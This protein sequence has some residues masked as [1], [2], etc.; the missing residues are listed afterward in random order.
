M[1]HTSSPRRHTRLPAL[2]VVVMLSVLAAPAGLSAQEYG[3]SPVFRGYRPSHQ[4]SRP[5]NP[6]PAQQ[7]RDLQLV[8]EANAG[9]Q[10]AQ[11]ELG[12]RYLFGDGFQPDTAKAA[13]WIGKAAA[14]KLALANYNYGL[15][16]ANGWGV[17]WD[18]FSAFRHIRFAAERGQTEAQHVLGLTYTENL[19]VAR[20]WNTALKW[21]RLA[22]DS[23]FT[24]SRA[25]LPELESV[26]RRHSAAD[27]ITGSTSRAEEDDTQPGA[28]GAWSPILLDFR[29]DTVPALPDAQA[30]A[31]DAITTAALRSADSAG[32]LVL[33]AGDSSDATLLHPLSPAAEAGNPEV[34]TFL[35]YCAQEGIGLT[36]DPVHAA[37][38]YIRAIYLESP[39]AAQFLWTLTRMKGFLG[40]LQARVAEGETRAMFVQSELI[41]LDFDGHI[42][43]KQAL[44][45]LIKAAD[46]GNSTAAVHV[47]I[48]QQTG[49]WVVQDREKALAIW[50]SAAAAGNAEAVVRAAAGTL[51]TAGATDVDAADHLTILRRADSHG[52]ILARVALARALETGIGVSRNPGAATR[53]YRACAQRGSRAALEAL[54]RM[55]DN[56]RPSDPLFR[57]PSAL[58]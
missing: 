40:V 23:G 29:R 45:L 7:W 13:Y 32:V 35:G 21:I 27:S 14:Q 41:A 15:L 53:L 48:C 4:K 52:S 30:L 6:D 12:L 10:F 42:T 8:R 9:D 2:T 38:L 44:D 56:I 36:R 19:V 55:H 51:L 5:I 11:H 18:P 39:R 28:S 46:R 57:I 54:R 3:N 34:L 37:E 20:D 25:I 58:R 50:R 47:G 17:T 22:A 31:R 43:E 26:A 16:L 24:P 1:T 49:R 33:A